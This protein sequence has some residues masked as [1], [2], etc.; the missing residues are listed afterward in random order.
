MK[1]IIIDD[2]KKWLDK[3][4][5]NINIVLKVEKLNIEIYQFEKYNPKLKK[6]LRDDSNK[7]YIIDMKLN[8]IE[9]LDIVHEIR[10]LLF[11][12]KSVIIVVSQYDRQKDL[13]SRRLSILTYIS[14][15]EHFNSD[16]RSSIDLGIKILTNN[17]F[18]ILKEGYSKYKI[19]INDII[20]VIK[21]K[22]TKYCIVKTKNNKHFRVRT[23]L[24]NINKELNF[25]RINNH[26]LENPNY[27]SKL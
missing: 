9:G 10:D 5:K 6:I 2:E 19:A 24:V 20:K 7:I 15:N 16:L 18:I 21:E 1:I 22:G 12:W 14:K 27:K 8:K 17:R 13:I 25:K 11:D 26:I 23:S 3:I 4:Y